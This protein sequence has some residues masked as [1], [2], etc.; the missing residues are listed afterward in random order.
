MGL[1]IF[2]AELVKFVVTVQV[3]FVIIA[4]AEQMEITS[5]I[6]T[7]SQNG[8]AQ[9]K[10]LV[11][12]NAWREILGMKLIR[13]PLPVAVEGPV[14]TPLMMPSKR[15]IDSQPGRPAFQSHLNPTDMSLVTLYSSA[16]RL[17]PLALPVLPAKSSLS[18]TICLRILLVIAMVLYI[19]R[20][21]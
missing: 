21:S 12:A 13:I 2:L 4:A 14:I 19:V 3:P 8:V 10:R 9:T 18:R 20:I 11:L 1:M 5:A 16:F 7:Q 17:G 6:T 15:P